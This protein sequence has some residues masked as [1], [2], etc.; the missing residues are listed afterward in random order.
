MRSNLINMV[1]VLFLMSLSLSASVDAQTII[2]KPFDIKGGGITF[3]FDF[4]GEGLRQKWMLPDGLVSNG[5]NIPGVEKKSGLD[6][7]L[8]VTGENR[9][10]HHG[11]KLTGG[12]PG[13]RL[14][15]SGKTETSIPGGKELVLVQTDSLTGLK[16][17][18]VY[19]LYDNCPVVRRFTRITKEGT[20]P[21]GI[22][23]VSSAMLNGFW[24]PVDN[25]FDDKIII[26]WAHNSWM[27]ESQ[28]HESKP[29]ELGWAENGAFQLSGIFFSSLGSWSSISYLPMAMVENKTLG[30]TWFWQIEHNGSWHWE[31]SNIG[32]TVRPYIYIGGPDAQ[33]SESW[34]N[35]KPGETYETVPVGIG[36]V[37]GGFEE[38]ITALTNYRRS[39][40]LMPHPFNR[41]IPVIFN[42][43]MNCLFG[44]PTTDKLIPLIDAAALAGCDYFTIDAGWY[45]EL[46]ETW[47]DAVG[48]W[49]PS[50]T[51]FPGGFQKVL[52]Y[53]KSK[54]MV[55]GLWLELEVAGT[56]SPLKDKPDSWFFMR[57]G[58]R[59][60]DNSR[61]LLDF[62]N[63]E[64][65]AH[66][67]E[68]I[69]RIAG[70]YGV[71]YIKMDYNVNALMGTETGSD[72]F[73][74]GL[75]EHNRAF[76]SWL[77]KVHL[78]YPTLVIENCASGGCRMDYAM[79][80]HTQIQSSTDQTDYKKYPC[81]LAGGLAAVLPEQIAAWSYPLPD[82]TTDE[83]AFNMVSA[84]ICRIHQ[85]G[86]LN[87]ISPERFALVKKGI[88]IYK[89]RI[90]QIIPESV[91]FFPL[92]TPSMA[93][94]VSPVAVGLKGKNRSVIAVWRL[95]GVSSVH[96][97]T[98]DGTRAKIL[99][100]DNLGIK[101]TDG[102][103]GFTLDFPRKYMA[104]IV[105]IENQN[106]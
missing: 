14:K 28:W 12:N 27:A 30:V 32:D 7:E 50:K 31:M 44:D 64:V 35:L 21:A 83:T 71:G 69:D 26:H 72:S 43:Y 103:T 60:I 6:V 58:K 5:T 94:K 91:P 106:R 76:L 57:H 19:R 51:R 13:L 66:A 2:N 45:A 54:G 53:I 100:P 11:I 98:I 70:K 96:I 59:V 101:I 1:I 67:D 80:S 84:M 85:S 88:E 86:Y 25:G 79:L 37:K 22:E 93:D 65:R 46:N 9:E 36:C 10:D 56:N 42:D 105:E 52:D 89:S 73:G 41:D 61:Y 92:G 34:K 49:Q 75:L 39:T 8:H 48:L 24:N 77:E 90:R 3:G 97:K 81:V 16:V 15:Y 82:G 20:K 40:C 62:R 104:A 99:Y 17:E 4:F 78:R 68:V 63:P 74:Q 87:K 29:S 18:S 33:Y 38:A 47:W 23:H 95:D 55:P 102:K